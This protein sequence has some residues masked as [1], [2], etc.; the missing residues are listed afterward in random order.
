MK[1]LIVED[2]YI[3][4]KWFELKLQA[5]CELTVC[6][7]AKSG[8]DKILTEKFDLIF[9]DHDLG[10]L[11]YVQSDENNTGYQVSKNIPKSI[12]DNSEIIIHSLNPVGVSNM[13]SVLKGMDVK[14]LPFGSFDCIWAENKLYIENRNEF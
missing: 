6:E 9:L 5:F 11:V 14:R 4:I 13:M 10:G 7:D 8:I 1:I 2:N 12:N 3:R